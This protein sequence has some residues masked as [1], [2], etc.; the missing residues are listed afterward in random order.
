MNKEII[1]AAVDKEIAK[2]FMKLCVEE[3]TTFSEKLE[4][5][6]LSFLSKGVKHRDEKLT[7]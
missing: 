4:S 6:V 2:K 7:A 5:L 1:T 3:N